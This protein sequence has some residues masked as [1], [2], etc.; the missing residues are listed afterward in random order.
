MDTDTKTDWIKLRLATA[1]LDGWRH[2]A[3]L[4]GESVSAYVRTAVNDRVELG[5]RLRG[6]EEEEA[7]VYELEQRA[8]RQLFERMERTSS[9]AGRRVR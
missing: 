3:S 4:A 2:A 9:P 6:L 8:A 5:A 7:R 1:E